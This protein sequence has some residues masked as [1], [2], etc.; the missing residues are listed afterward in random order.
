MPSVLVNDGRVSFIC[1]RD[2][3]YDGVEY[4]LGDDFDQDLGLGRID[5]LVRTRRLYPVVDSDRDRPRHWHH[6]IWE[7]DVIKKKLGVL[8]REKSTTLT[9]DSLYNKP[10][11]MDLPQESMEYEPQEDEGAKLLAQASANAATEEVLRQENE[12]GKYSDDNEYIDPETGEEQTEPTELV[13][14]AEEGDVETRDE[15]TDEDGNV[16]VGEPE[17]EEED[18]REVEEEDLYD[19]TDYGVPEVNEYLDSDITDEERQRVL[20]VEAVNKNR[21]GIMNRG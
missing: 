7:R 12:E 11:Q 4:K 21:K 20:A 1:A 3:V 5:L 15:V 17:D 2:F 16:I 14:P 8:N 19:P 9:G 18:E 13:N 6:H 10:T